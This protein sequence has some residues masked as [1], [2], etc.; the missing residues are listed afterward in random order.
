MDYIAEHEVGFLKQGIDEK[1]MNG[2]DVGCG[3]RKAIVSAV[4][5]DVARLEDTDLSAGQITYAEWI[6]D[7]HVL[8]FKDSVMDYV[9]SRH[10][11]EHMNW[12]KAIIEWLR[13]LKIGGVLRSV[14][15]N[16]NHE[17]HLGHGIAQ[18]EMLEFLS[19]LDILSSQIE[20]VE[21]CDGYSWGL[22]IRKRS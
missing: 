11:L 9:I 7:G 21:L 19:I 2:V 5:L 12:K 14:I 10:V 3:A 18:I 4:G 22:A 17:H 20:I 15:P 8:P 6:C 13:C 1:N 16:P